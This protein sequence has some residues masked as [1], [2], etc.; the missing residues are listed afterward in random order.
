MIELADDFRQNFGLARP[1]H[2][3]ITQVSLFC[4]II[5]P[6]FHYTLTFEHNEIVN[7]Q[8]IQKCIQ[9]NN[10]KIRIETPKV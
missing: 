5:N 10:A 7:A 1:K 4:L 9:C 8:N 6:H 2:F 3:A